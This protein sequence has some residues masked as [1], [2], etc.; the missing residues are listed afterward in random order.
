MRQKIRIRRYLPRGTDLGKISDEQIG[1]IESLI[2]NRPGKWP[3]F[4]KPIEATASFVALR[5]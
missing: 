5:G 1:R 4:R 2:N 3:G